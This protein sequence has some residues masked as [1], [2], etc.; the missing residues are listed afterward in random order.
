MTQK[1]AY[2]EA[3]TVLFEEIID[4]LPKNIRKVIIES[5]WRF[6]PQTI[7]LAHQYYYDKKYPEYKIVDWLKEIE[8][9]NLKT[10]KE[11]IGTIKINNTT[12]ERREDFEP[13]PGF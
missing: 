4:M 11:E 9:K 3:L 6:S 8:R 10:W 5:D 2:H 1:M 12:S 7:V 13:I